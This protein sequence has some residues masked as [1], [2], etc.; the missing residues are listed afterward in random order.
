ML[1]R[2]NQ[3]IVGQDSG[4]GRVVDSE[5]ISSDTKGAAF[6]L[7]TVPR[8]NHQLIDPHATAIDKN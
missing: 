8:T 4:G 6:F 3:R 2:R 1:A 5:A 7:L